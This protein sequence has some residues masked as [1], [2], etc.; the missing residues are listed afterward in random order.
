MSIIPPPSETPSKL[1]SESTP[2][3]KPTPQNPLPF[4]DLKSQQGLIRPKI[5]EAIQRVLDH[6]VYIMGPEVA[7]LEADLSDF[8]GAKYPISCANGTDALALGLMAKNIGPGDAIFV[9][10]F[11]F[12]ATA[13]V[14]SWV[15]ATVVFIDSLPGTFN[16]DPA[17]L[18]QAIGF[19]KGAGLRARGV[20][21]VD[22]FGQPADYDAVEAIADQNRLWIMADGAQSFGAHYKGRRVGTIGHM[23]TTSFFPAKPLGCYGDGGAIFTD[24]EELAGILKSLRVHGQGVDKYENIRIGMNGRLDTL[25]AAILIEKLKIF[26]GEIQARQE[27]AHRYRAGISDRI[28]T[29]DV[30]EGATSTWAQYTLVLPE[31]INRDAFMQT[32]KDQ[33]IPTFIYYVKPLHLQEAYRSNPTGTGAGLPVCERLARR[34]VSLPMHPYLRVDVQDYIMNC[35]NKA[36]N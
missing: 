30:M 10:S 24:D 5:D 26:E 33:G 1:F 16:M 27:I 6:G 23:S 20:I 28:I 7:Q 34:V 35:I 14:V 11:T 22:L 13:E 19:A 3:Q 36:V 2:F 32:L 17:G 15:G 31:D 18:D 12:A 29:Q 4:I 21:P 25:Q 9:P 8:S